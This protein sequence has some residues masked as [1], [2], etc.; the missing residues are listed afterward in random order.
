AWILPALTNPERSSLYWAFSLLYCVPLLRNGFDIDGYVL[1]MLVL[2]ILHVQAERIA[3]TEPDTLRNIRLLQLL[4]R[5]TVLVVEKGSDFATSLFQTLEADSQ[6]IAQGKG[7]KLL[8]DDSLHSRDSKDLEAPEDADKYQLKEFD[9][10][11]LER[12]KRE[13]RQQLPPQQPRQRQRAKEE[14]GSDNHG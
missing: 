13:N 4:L 7:D 14:E 3:L 8:G 10:R 2:G 5:A 11:M 6:R 12:R 1:A 9:R